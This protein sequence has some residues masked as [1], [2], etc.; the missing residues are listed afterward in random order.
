M[1]SRWL[2]V[3]LGLLGAGLVLLAASRTWLVVSVPGLPGAA[4]TTR[5]GNDVAPALP[6]LA[7]AG[8]ACSAVLG[9]S[10]RVVRPVTSALM[11]L[12]GAA[13]VV[14]VL[15]DD[16]VAATTEVGRSVVW[17]T[18]TLVGAG[19]VL[20]AGLVGLARSRTWPA[21]TRRYERGRPAPAPEASTAA[22]VDD[23]TSLSQGHDPT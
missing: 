7:L 23:W 17:P 13:I 3:G 18:L 5:S 11:V 1:R 14:A 19:L 15:T 16:G 8:A 22:P 2:A 6:A 21:P 10:G 12:A 4:G 9:T 20:V